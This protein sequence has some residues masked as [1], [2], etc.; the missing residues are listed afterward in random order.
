MNSVSAW[1]CSVRRVSAKAASYLRSSARW[2]ARCV[3]HCVTN[4]NPPPTS[5]PTIEEIGVQ[6]SPAMLDN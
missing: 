2:A 6:N 1:I 3:V 5:T 4:V